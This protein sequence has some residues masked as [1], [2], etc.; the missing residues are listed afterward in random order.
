MYNYARFNDL[1]YK[2]NVLLFK[3]SFANCKRVFKE[4][5]VHESNSHLASFFI[6]ILSA[7]SV[8]TSLI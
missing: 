5:E 2:R 4:H 3:W 7:D 6:V 8:T 1:K